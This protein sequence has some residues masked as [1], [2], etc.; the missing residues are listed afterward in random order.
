MQKILQIDL[1]KRKALENLKNLSL[2][3]FGGVMLFNLNKDDLIKDNDIFSMHNMN[4]FLQLSLDQFYI[5]NA[6]LNIL[7]FLHIKKHIDIKE[8][9]HINILINS[10]TLYKNP[11]L[12]YNT[13]RTIS[14]DDNII[15]ALKNTSSIN[16]AFKNLKEL[17]EVLLKENIFLNFIDLNSK[18]SL[19][20][21]YNQILS[22]HHLKDYFYIKNNQFFIKEDI[23]N[24]IVFHNINSSSIISNYLSLLNDFNTL[25]KIELINILESLSLYNLS[26][27][28]QTI[29][30]RYLKLEYNLKSFDKDS[31]FLSNMIMNVR[32]K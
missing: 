12:Q 22:N 3:G 14:K 28:M 6:F 24:K 17:Q 19:L 5:P 30:K 11:L 23:K 26:T 21:F 10:D 25:S 15:Y 7:E 32:L 2:L 29:Q 4:H 8:S 16:Q 13:N 1:E 20:G 9:F 18:E 27:L 31:I